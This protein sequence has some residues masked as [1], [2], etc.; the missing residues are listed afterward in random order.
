MR[1]KLLLLSIVPLLLTSCGA[2]KVPLQTLID[3]VNK[4]ENTG[5]HP[6]YR[7]VGSIDMA[8]SIKEITDIDGLF[9][10]QP[11][12]YSYVENARYNEGFYCKRAESIQLQAGETSSDVKEENIVITAM[13]S[14]SY[15]L[16][17]PLRLHK[18]NFYAEKADGTLNMSCGFGNLRLVITS[19]EG[20]PGAV[21]ASSNKPYYEI[22]PNGGFA[23]GGKS[24]RSKIFIDNYPYYMSYERHPELMTYIQ[25]TGEW[26]GWSEDRPL[27]CYSATKN[28]YIDGRFNMRFEYDAKGWLQSEYL[29]T[30]GY[31]YS[32]VSDSQMA[33]RSVYTYTFGN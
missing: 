10:K 23:I 32:E 6:Y 11:N 33:L 7:V 13:S 12:G 25:A 15:W 28:Y 31:D 27:P 20:S 5:E 8:G 30:V 18:E 17:A 4:I 14:R 21:N 1:K 19:F 9:D 29:E 24:V 3:H 2:N 16:R 22:L 26:I